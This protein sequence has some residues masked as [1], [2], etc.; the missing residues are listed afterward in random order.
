MTKESEK[1]VLRVSKIFS[2]EDYNDY[3]SGKLTFC[4]LMCKY[5][6]TCHVLLL[7]FDKLG[8]CSRDKYIKQGLNEHLFDSI[9]SEESAYVL[10]FYVADGCITNNRIAF[11]ISEKDF[12]TLQAIQQ[13]L[14][15]NSNIQHYP[16]RHNK[17]GYTCYPM[18]HFAVSSKHICEK[19]TEY[20]L[21]K[22]KTYL[23]KS[24][25]NIVPKEYMWHFI[26]GYFDGDGCVSASNIKRIIKG[27]TYKYWNVNWTIISHDKN[28]LEELQEFI[29]NSIESP[30][31][32]YPEKRGNYLMGTHTKHILP[33]IFEKLYDNATIYMSRKYLKFKNIIANT[34][35]SSEI[36]KGSETP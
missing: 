10:G 33:K 28:I 30:I 31:L 9:N 7:L 35:V 23:S 8:L 24:I 19:L 32:L 22:Q 21:G 14:S 12:D 6:C 5:Q 15:S 13:I 34:E 3:L 18:C 4:N 16:E 17:Q 1:E 27:K 20:G 25:V 11:S 29:S 36:T 26:R 2:K